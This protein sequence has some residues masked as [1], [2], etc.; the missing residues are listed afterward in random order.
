MAPGGYRARVQFAPGQ[1]VV[2]R[3][4][5]D[6]DRLVIAHCGRVVR[7]DDRGLLLWTPAGTVNRR[8]KTADGRRFD[9]V[10]RSEWEAAD[11]VL[12]EHVLRPYSMLIWMP[13][14]AAHSIG[15]FFDA[16]GTFAG[17][18]VN[19]ES[20]AVRW[21]D[22]LD[23]VDHDLDIVVAP[24]RQWRWKDEED[25]DA[26][27]RE[28][29]DWSPADAVE[30]RAEAERLAK[31]VDAGVFPFDGTWCDFRPDPAWPVPVLPTGWDRPRA[32]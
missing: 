26:S 22:G 5:R 11:K 14:A 10:P 1:V 18:Y 3:Y 4:F 6:R 8:L 30:I 23:L 15:W 17:W 13:P 7:D 29:V 21:A 2:R 31:L 20:P 12:A 9:Q 19:L 28:G 32:G 27:S 16:T 25:F 24:D